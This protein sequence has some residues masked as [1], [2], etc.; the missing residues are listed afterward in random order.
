MDYDNQEKRPLL[1]NNKLYLVKTKQYLHYSVHFSA[2]RTQGMMK[3][4]L[5]MNGMSITVKQY[6]SNLRLS[7]GIT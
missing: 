1:Y 2:R 7:L 6:L 4:N 3:D 5:I